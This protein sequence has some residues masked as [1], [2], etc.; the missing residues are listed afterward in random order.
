M[1]NLTSQK[2]THE[3]GCLSSSNNSET[4][5]CTEPRKWESRGDYNNRTGLSSSYSFSPMERG[6]VLLWRGFPIAIQLCDD[7]GVCSDSEVGGNTRKAILRRHWLCKVTI[8][9][10]PVFVRWGRYSDP[11]Y[12][13]CIPLHVGIDAHLVALVAWHAKCGHHQADTTTVS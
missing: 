7:Q 11:P 4:I 10:Q 5:S 3:G 13:Y 8:D 1:Q 2:R 6:Q 9:D 12:H